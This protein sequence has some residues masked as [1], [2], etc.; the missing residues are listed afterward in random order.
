MDGRLDSVLKLYSHC[1]LMLTKNSNVGNGQ[2]NGSR[3]VYQ[4]MKLKVGEDAFPLKLKCGT[5][6][7]GVCAS[8]M[9][10]IVVKHVVDDITPSIFKVK[11]V[12][13]KLSVDLK[14][15]DE[16]KKVKMVGQQFPLVSNSCTL[17]R[18]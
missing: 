18:I 14:I 4:C 13:G 17:V 3:V 5:T 15:R 12:S 11:S 6:I 2:A 9:D 1:P 16:S 10:S 8:H 7:L